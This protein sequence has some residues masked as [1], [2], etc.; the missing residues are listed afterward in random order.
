MASKG[1]SL[2]KYFKPERYQLKIDGVNCSLIIS[3]Q[4]LGPPSKRISLNQQKLKVISAAISRIDRKNP[5]EYP[6]DRI[7]HLPS[8]QQVRLHTK[9]IQYPGKY[10]VSLSYKISPDAAASLKSL[11]KAKP[12]RRLVPCVDEAEAWEQAEFELKS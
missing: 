7:N 4:K 1:V 6:V 12:D 11:S 2:Y 5:G 9:H 3:G 8:F 10:Q